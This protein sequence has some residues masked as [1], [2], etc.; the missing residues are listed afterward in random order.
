ME[1]K[2]K[3]SMKFEPQTIEHLGIKMYSILPNAMAELI[4]N[5]YDAEAT[6]VNIKLFDDNDRKKI[7]IID[8]GG[9][10]SFKEIDEKFLIIGKKRREDD[11]GW[12]PNK[13]RK[14]T[15]RK[16]LGKLAFFGIG[17][18]ITVRTRKDGICTEFTM[19]WQEIKSTTNHN[20]EPKFK[21]FE[22]GPHEHGTEIELFNLKRK[23]GFDKQ[24][25]AISISKLFNFFDEDFKVYISLNDQN[26]TL[27]DYKLKYNDFKQ[28]IIWDIPSDIQD[29]SLANYFNENKICG[30]IVASEKPLKPGLR[31][32]TLFA[33]GRLVNTPEFFGVGE[34]SH[35]YSYLIGWLDVDFIDE[36]EEDMVSTDRQSL[37]WD[38]PIAENLKSNLKKLLSSV[39][40]DWRNKRKNERQKQISQSTSFQ[41]TDWYEKLPDAL[42]PGVENIVNTVV[43]KSEL[44]NET[45]NNLIETLHTLI[46]EYAYYHWRNLHETV[47]N[48]SEQ[49]YKN[50]DFYM[51]VLEPIKRYESTVQEKI[52]LFD[53]DGQDLM[54][55]SFGYKK[56][57]E[58]KKEGKEKLS[59]SKKY[60]KSN[61]MDFSDKTKDNIEAGQQYLSAGIMAGVR[62]T[63][64]HEEITYLKTSGLFTEKD[65]LDMLSLISHLFRRLDDAE[66][67]TD[68]D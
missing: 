3:L 18:T 20:Y 14:V 21:Q 13:K 46:P 26:E 48:I 25:L 32:I 45:Q 1:N 67:I 33:R 61:R 64:A 44:P 24:S 29:S 23:S 40:K 39:E 63:L 38:L 6:V 34:S 36:L 30:E 4:A 53:K 57:N 10:M 66:K 68:N 50:K 51:A 65:C 41:L 37:N 17:D 49:Y 15:G 35:A 59:V 16:G 54:F 2:D 58:K 43:E 5:A 9:G 31:G 56:S 42:Q 52:G 12:S 8:N 28:Q 22:C 62:N 7:L 55:Q 27:I 19:D 47:R 11:N 60:K